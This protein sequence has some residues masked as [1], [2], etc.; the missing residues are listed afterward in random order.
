MLMVYLTK[1]LI[2]A[3]VT[4]HKSDLLRHNPLYK[5]GIFI[6]TLPHVSAAP[7]CSKGASPEW[8]LH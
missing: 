1:Y 7:I 4:S 6:L 8:Q 3:G 2:F 5:C